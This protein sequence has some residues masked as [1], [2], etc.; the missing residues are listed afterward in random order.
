MSGQAVSQVEIDT[1]EIEA[2][3]WVTLDWLINEHRSVAGGEQAGGQ[4]VAGVHAIG[5]IASERPLVEDR[6]RILLGDE[7]LV[8][9]E[10]ATE[11]PISTIPYGSIHA[12]AIQRHD[13]ADDFLVVAPGVAII[14]RQAGVGVRQMVEHS[15]GFPVLK[16]KLQSSTA[17]VVDTLTGIP[18]RPEALP[19]PSSWTARPYGRNGGWGPRRYPCPRSGRVVWKRR[20]LA[21]TR[22]SC[23]WCWVARGKSGRQWEH[24]T[25]CCRWP[26]P[27]MSGHCRRS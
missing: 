26:R 7:A 6:A 20:R 9:Q 22:N 27:W 2:T 24:R 23:A 21:A 16:Q 5:G 15:L 10:S 1:P 18:G 13:P 25:A 4:L 8:L 14:V 11:V 19:R 17:V 12:C 3:D